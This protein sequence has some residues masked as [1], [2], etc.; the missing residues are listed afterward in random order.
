MHRKICDLCI[1]ENCIQCEDYS[2]FTAHPTAVK[3]K[4]MTNALT[5]AV[6]DTKCSWVSSGV[7]DR[8]FTTCCGK[9]IENEF[10]RSNEYKFCPFCGKRLELKEEV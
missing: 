4:V 5:V 1:G 3:E 10:P 9:K 6:E 8:K 2:N 7:I